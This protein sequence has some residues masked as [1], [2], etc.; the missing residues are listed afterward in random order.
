MSERSETEQQILDATLQALMTH[1]YANLTIS[2]V[3]EEFEKSPS[4]IYHYFDSKDELMAELYD[5]LSNVYFDFIREID[6]DDP[7]ERLRFLIEIILYSDE[8][9]PDDE[10]YISLY[11]IMVHVPHSKT[12]EEKY[13]QNERKAIRLMAN[14]LRE[15][16]E[17][18]QIKQTDPV[19]TAAF[20]S[21]AID[22]VRLHRVLH[23]DD[24]TIEIPS[25]VI[26][27]WLI[28]PLLAENK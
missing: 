8:Y 6:I 5:Y 20:L 16:M 9:T 22:G 18:G 17:T 11:E 12:L 19:Q 10:F 15:G 14:I 4:L 25:D 2:D 13:I 1:G 26:D 28:D 27:H 23:S 21:A 3:S 24:E 7:I